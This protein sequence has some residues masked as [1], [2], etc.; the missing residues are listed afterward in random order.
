M[1]ISLLIIVILTVNSAIF[2]KGSSYDKSYL[3]I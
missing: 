3:M 1:H 2:G